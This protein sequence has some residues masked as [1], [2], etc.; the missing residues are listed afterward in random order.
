MSSSPLSP[1]H[2]RSPCQTNDRYLWER[3]LNARTFGFKQ[4][5][6]RYWRL[7][8]TYTDTTQVA[9]GTFRLRC[10]NPTLELHSSESP[11]SCHGFSS[12]YY[13][14]TSTR[15]SPV[16]EPDAHRSCSIEVDAPTSHVA[17]G[18]K[19]RASSLTV[20][21]SSMDVAQSGRLDGDAS[22][23]RGGMFSGEGGEG[24][25][26]APDA[27]PVLID[28]CGASAVGQERRSGFGAMS[29]NLDRP[30]QPSHRRAPNER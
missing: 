20:R 8:S 7:R 26:G 10:G 27:I 2:T 16:G 1:T 17:V 19:I 21:A 14:S 24:P 23:L 29:R 13:S 4:T 11:L 6:A 5:T 15:F 25:G 28:G 9:L 12:S 30:I 22:G 3:N 18:G